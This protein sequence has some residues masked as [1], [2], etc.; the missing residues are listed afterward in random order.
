MEFSQSHPVRGRAR[1]ADGDGNVLNAKSM[2]FTLQDRMA[3]TRLLMMDERKLE[4]KKRSLII[5]LL[6]LYKANREK[7]LL[8][9]PL[10]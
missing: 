7:A 2:A 4:R 9:L 3:I 1:L 10:R 5:T 8:F 6:I